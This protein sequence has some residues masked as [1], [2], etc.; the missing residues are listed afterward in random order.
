MA[1]NR[2]VVYIT[3]IPK[4]DDL[5]D[6]V[7]QLM[8]STRSMFLS[9]E[10]SISHDVGVVDGKVHVIETYSSSDDAERFE[11]MEEHDRMIQSLLP[12]VS[13]DIVVVKME[14]VGGDRGN[15]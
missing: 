14:T 2:Y 1:C 15:M 7:R 11:K 4:S 6:E 12:L 8:I 3:L 5:L 10:G 9:L 13:P